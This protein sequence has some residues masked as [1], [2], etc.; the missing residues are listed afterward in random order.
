[1]APK[2]Q[3]EAVIDILEA[4]EDNREATLHDMATAIVNKIEALRKK[5]I[6]DA[7]REAVDQL[8]AQHPLHVVA[9]VLSPYA[10]ADNQLVMLGPFRSEANARAAGPSLAVSPNKMGFGTWRTGLWV[11]SARVA[12]D[13]MYA[14]TEDPV[15]WIKEQAR[16]AHPGRW[17]AEYW[18]KR[19]A[20]GNDG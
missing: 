13:A 7:R 3:V 2:A 12:W 8:H 1:M 4:Y 18:E 9:G 10:G 6:D 20:S 11:S 15:K 14:P 19:N 5:S 17:A 16:E